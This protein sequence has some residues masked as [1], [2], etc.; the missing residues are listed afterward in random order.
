MATF[1]L[2]FTLRLA[3][4]EE[5]LQEACSVRARAY[6]H[7]LPE[8]GHRMEEPDALD[9]AEG[10]AVFLCRDKASGRGTGTLRIQASA[11]GPLLLERSLILPA[12]LAAMPRAEITR[13]AVLGGADPL[14]KLCLMKASYLYCLASQQRW[15]VIG[16]R[17]EALIRN[18]RRLGFRD[19]LDPEDRVPLAHAGGLPHRILAF[20]V[21][22][23]ERTW[24]EA[25]HPLYGFMVETFHRDIQLFQQGRAGRLPSAAP[26]PRR[27][28][29][30][31]VA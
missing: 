1:T 26:L 9:H 8:M 16:A 19:V 20:D 18:Y 13:L 10:T 24:Q 17:N 25:R 22:A 23:A 6:G 15:M 14:T 2:D 3:T 5:D 12:A 31:A 27:A 4:S 28:R 11:F 29:L 7:H 21:A 30:A